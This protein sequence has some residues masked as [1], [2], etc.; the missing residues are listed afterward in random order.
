MADSQTNIVISA[1]DK[2]QEAFNSISAN[3]GKLQGAMGA[4]GAT[5]SVGAF[6]AWQKSLIDAADEMQDLSQRVGIGIQ[7]LAGYK[8]AAEQ[9]G[10][11]MEAVA[12]GVKALS[13]Y[14]VEHSDKLKAAGITAKDADTALQQLSEVFANM[15]DGVQKTALATQLFGKAGMEA[16]ERLMGPPPFMPPQ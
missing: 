11:S 13:T 2:T 5:L 8:L 6:V 16:L 4:L 9:S 7:Q 10:T 3:I 1:V 14:M 12:K 15:P